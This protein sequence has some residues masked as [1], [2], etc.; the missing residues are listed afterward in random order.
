M[1]G[2]DVW[3][4][5]NSTILSGVNIGHGA[6]IANGAIVSRDVEPYAIVAGNPAARIRCS[7]DEHVRTQLLHSAWWEW[8]E[9]EIRQTVSLLCSDDLTGFLAYARSRPDAGSSKR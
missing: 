5:A 6:V 4:C 3:I 7:F 8:P 9:G 2:S 1:I